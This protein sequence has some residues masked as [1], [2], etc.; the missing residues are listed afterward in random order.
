MKG[1][2]PAVTLR[3][4]A[5]VVSGAA[6]FLFS[7]VVAAQNLVLP[8]TGDKQ[9]N[10]PSSGS[11]AS[12]DAACVAFYSDATNLL[13]QG[14]SGDNNGFTDVFVSNLEAG[15]LEIASIGVDGEGANGPSMAQGFRPSID[16]GCT[17]VSF[18]SDASNLVPGDTNRRTDVFVR[19]LGDSTVLASVGMDEPA[20][21]ASSYSS[22]SAACGRVAFQ[23]TASNLVPGDENLTSDIFVY[24]R[25]SGA[26]DRVNMGPGGVEADGQSIT[27]SIS[28]DGRCVAFASRASNL[29][30][31]DTNGVNDIYVACD[32]A[33]TCRASVSSVGQQ[34]DKISFHPA[35]S[36][37]GNIVAFKSEAT[38]LVDDDFNG[39]PDIFVH[40]CTSGD[41]QRVSVSTGGAEGNDI[42]IPPTIT[43]DG[44]KVA[45]GS[46]ASNLLSGTST[47]GHSQ[48]YVRDLEIGATILISSSPNGSAQNGG[49]PD[50]QPSI[51]PEGDWVTFASLATNLVPGDSNGYQDVFTGSIGAPP[52]TPAP[53]T[54]TPMPIPCDLDTDCPS[55][56]VCNDEGICVAAPT[57]TPK[58]PCDTVEDCPPGH[59]CIGN[60]CVD[61]ATPTP[62]PTP[63]PQCDVDEDCMEG[64]V[65]RAL[66]CVP[67]RDCEE[68]ALECRGIRETCLDGFCECG[69]DCN[70]NGLVFGTEISTMMCQLGGSC[71]IDEC[72]AGDI[73]QDGEVTG[74]EVSLAVRNLG[75]GC[76]GEG[77]PLIFG[78]NRTTEDRTINI[79]TNEGAPGEIV[80]IVI[81]LEGGDEV[82]TTQTD[83]LIPTDL[84]DVTITQAGNGELRPNCDMDP[85]LVATFFPE[86][87]LPQAPRNTDGLRR[88]RVAQVDIELPFPLD[89]FG[90]GPL[91]NCKFRVGRSVDVGTVIPLPG[92][93]ERT[94]VGDPNAQEF[95]S[96]VSDGSIT[97]VE[98]PPCEVDEDCPDG[99]FC[100]GM[101]CVPDIECVAGGDECLSREACV[102]ERCACGVDCNG[103]GDVLVNEILL[104]IG[105][106]AGNVGLDQCPAA[107][108]NGD[109]DVL[110]NEL[111]LGIQN[112]AQGCP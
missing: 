20:N 17:C 96:I 35:L 21:G 23:S 25:G 58:I 54:P 47:G 71:E 10:G 59:D 4:A 105:I 57:P 69:G 46:F 33:I 64:F 14:S 15:T 32:G 84:V 110:V 55:G 89:S 16:D 5:L 108:I 87:R 100:R 42:S 85:R 80:D 92:D 82:T 29:W 90:E 65:C 63:L 102:D 44:M 2:F 37:D 51:S 56:Q 81:S 26:V 76:P 9:A 88:L 86:I 39:Q 106:F 107:D 70:L 34:A 109:T 67:R 28:A 11:V 93:P 1:R 13:P 99:L 50:V 7:T 74:C 111:L 78:A 12:R 30:P 68:G 22:V 27:P 45:F 6:I 61:Q 94:E 31:D 52:P 98:P 38:N 104:A 112:F 103:D 49:S 53:P 48:I 24:D 8:A 77:V 36:A 18:S 66:V 95:N 75:L 91:F 60:I 72:A 3:L 73:N 43:D 79:G 83:I 40:N 19:L 62:T 101:V 41:T 97:V